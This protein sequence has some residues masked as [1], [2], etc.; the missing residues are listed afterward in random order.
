MGFVMLSMDQLVELRLVT[1]HTTQVKTRPEEVKA[2]IKALDMDLK[3]KIK[4]TPITIT[5]VIAQT[6][7]GATLALQIALRGPR[8]PT[9][10]GGASVAEEIVA[11][12]VVDQTHLIGNALH[13]NLGPY[14]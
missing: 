2:I 4:A 10:V 3:D 11:E 8:P 1:N 12:A 13:L 14:S 5:P 6:V 7:A 9:L